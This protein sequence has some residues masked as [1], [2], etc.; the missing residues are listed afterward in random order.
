MAKGRALLVR[1]DKIGDLVL[2]LP[3]DGI[4]ALKEYTTHWLISRGTGFVPAHA[5]PAR[6]YFEAEKGFSWREFRRVV[7][8]IKHF[9]PD[10]AIV[11]HA[12]WWLGLALLCARVPSRIGRLSQWH[13]F[14]FFNHGVRQ[15][16]KSGDRH[17]SDLN[18]E[19]ANA[20]LRFS[21]PNDPPEPLA[22]HPPLPAA[23]LEAWG[24]EPRGYAVVHP[25][26]AG[27]ALNWP[28]DHYAAL[29][30]HLSA[31]GRVAV[32]G[33]RG[34]LSILD[35]VRASLGDAPGV[36]WLDEKLTSEQLLLVLACAKA[37]IAPSTG[38]LHLSAAL[39]TPS[40]GLYS[41][42][43]VQ[44]P[45]RWGARGR[46]VRNLVSPAGPED[47]ERD[48]AGAMARITPDQVTAALG[49]MKA[50]QP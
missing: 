9:R 7:K 43:P 33:T 12:P 47:A 10:V 30:R 25:G 38:V 27:S 11:F 50:L 44:R 17:E 5:A 3:A 29:I 18:V 36:I 39:G 37:V 16:R 41:P 1:M 34:D 14:L 48:P 42:I 6:P 28:P 26:M 24:L 4:P 45:T 2:S 35:R 49:E 22:L 40:V 23:A 21:G 20:G 32:T 31:K 46:L 13:S 19:L 8:W 15:S